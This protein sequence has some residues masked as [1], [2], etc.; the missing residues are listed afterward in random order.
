MHE[1]N[2]PPNGD[3]E[4]SNTE[5]LAL[6]LNYLADPA[7]I[8]CPTCGPGTIEVVAYLDAGGIAE[9]VVRA[10]SPEGDYT[11]VL[12]CHDCKRAA[13]L[14][15]GPDRVPDESESDEESDHGESDRW[16]A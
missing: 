1:E 16:A 14:D 6:A 5:G 8:P 3:S 10:A 2:R 13:A 7:D 9:G 4:F 15:L 11:V 12:Y